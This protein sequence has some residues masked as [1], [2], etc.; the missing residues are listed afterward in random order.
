MCD[1]THNLVVFF[2]PIE[3]SL[4]VPNTCDFSAKIQNI[5]FRVKKKKKNTFE[6]KKFYGFILKTYIVY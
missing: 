1:T 5:L 3:T 6:E 2:F 4:Q